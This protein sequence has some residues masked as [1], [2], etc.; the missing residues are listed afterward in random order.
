MSAIT[1]PKVGNISVSF[2]A[3]VVGADPSWNKRRYRELQYD[4]P[5]PG[6]HFYG[7]N[8]NTGPYAPFGA[9]PDFNDDVG[10]DFSHTRTA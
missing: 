4:F 8:E 6:R 9:S 3:L 5:Y 2:L 10:D 1:G 7:N